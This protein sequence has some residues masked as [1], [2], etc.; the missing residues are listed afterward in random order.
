MHI[1]QHI[2]GLVD[3]IYDVCIY[4]YFILAKKQKMTNRKQNVCMVMI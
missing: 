1:E 4:F 2:D 3:C